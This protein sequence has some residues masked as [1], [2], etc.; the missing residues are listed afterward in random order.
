[1]LRR[2]AI[3]LGA[4]ALALTLAGPADGRQRPIVYVVVLDGLDGDRI[5]AGRAP[6]ISSLLAGDRAAAGPTSPTR[7]R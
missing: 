5:E 1:M 2:L 3:C 6:F 4:V 7:A